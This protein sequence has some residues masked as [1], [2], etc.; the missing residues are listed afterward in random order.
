MDMLIGV[1]DR[2]NE[3]PRP[4]VAA[5]DPKPEQEWQYRI[6]EQQRLTDDGCPLFGPDD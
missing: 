3:P 4:D 2:R 1:L 5:P 6:L